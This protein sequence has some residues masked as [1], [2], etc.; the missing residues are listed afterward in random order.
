METPCQGCGQP[1]VVSADE[2]GS[3]RWPDWRLQLCERCLKRA[4]SLSWHYF[5]RKGRE[6][7][8]AAAESVASSS[9]APRAARGGSGAPGGA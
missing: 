9:V 7:R 6:R 1:A 4:S 3:R 8:A 2:A 5:M